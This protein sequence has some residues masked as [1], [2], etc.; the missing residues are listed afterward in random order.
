MGAAADGVAS[1]LP[2]LPLLLLLMFWIG[3]T[4]CFNVFSAV[5]LSVGVTPSR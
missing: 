2:L 3:A 5:D 1:V 4:I